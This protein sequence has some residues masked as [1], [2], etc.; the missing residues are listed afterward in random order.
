MSDLKQLG[1]TK[2]VKLPSKPQKMWLFLFLYFVQFLK[3]IC[4]NLYCALWKLAET[5][6]LHKKNI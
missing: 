4:S 3:Q 1:K 6:L 2:L 5:L